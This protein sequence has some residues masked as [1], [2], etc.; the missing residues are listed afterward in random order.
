MANI[1]PKAVFQTLRKVKLSQDD[2]KKDI[3][4][5]EH[6]GVVVVINGECKI[7]DLN[8]EKVKNDPDLERKI[9]DTINLAISSTQRKQVEALQK[10]SS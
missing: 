6:E 2:L 7:L 10:L 4:E 1:D 3:Q 8:F 9:I 5:F